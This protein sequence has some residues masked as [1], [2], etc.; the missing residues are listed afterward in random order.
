MMIKKFPKFWNVD[1]TPPTTPR[2]SHFIP[3]SNAGS[4]L[5]IGGIKAAKKGIRHIANHVMVP[6]GKYIQRAEMTPAPTRQSAID[7]P[8]KNHPP[9]P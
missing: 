1:C 2:C 9:T 4:N 6:K 7:P 8:S 3:G 5:I